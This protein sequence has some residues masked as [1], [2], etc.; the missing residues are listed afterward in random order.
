MVDL[1]MDLGLL[2]QLKDDLT[3]IST[4]FSN[5][6]DF[7][8]DVA[9]ATGH[10]D[11]SH[12][13]QEFADKWN[14]KRAKMVEAIDALQATVGAVADAFSEVDEGFAKALEEGAADTAKNNPNA[15]PKASGPRNPVI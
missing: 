3:A 5:A 11:L 13:V 15:V 2:Q 14:D 12:H 1:I 6:D 7:S 4:E 9:D 10:D 8:Q